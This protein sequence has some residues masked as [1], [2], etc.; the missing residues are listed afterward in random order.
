MRAHGVRGAVPEPG[1]VGAP[2]NQVY[3]DGRMNKILKGKIM[4]KNNVVTSRCSPSVVFI[5]FM[6]L[7]FCSTRSTST[8]GRLSMGNDLRGTANDV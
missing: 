3:I 2:C 6:L 4:A 5:A 7:S 1:V 8:L